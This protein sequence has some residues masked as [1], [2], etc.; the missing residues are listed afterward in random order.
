MHKNKD[1]EVKFSVLLI[2]LKINIPKVDFLNVYSFFKAL[3]ADK[4][5]FLL[6]FLTRALARSAIV[7]V[8]VVNSIDIV[9]I[10][11]GHFVLF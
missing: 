11:G 8:V 1:R 2:L 3:R 6:K 5:T 4:T 7:V 9:L 10:Y